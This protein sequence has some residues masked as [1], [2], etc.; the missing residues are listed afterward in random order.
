M[1]PAEIDNPQIIG[2]T[3]S[4]GSGCSYIAKN[5]LKKR[6]YEILSL[7][8]ILKEEF[9]TQKGKDAVKSPRRELQDFGDEIREEK[10]RDFL[11]SKVI[12]Q[13]DKSVAKNESKKWVVKSIRNPS[14]VLAFR[15]RS[16]NF[17]LFGVYADVE[18]RWNRVRGEYNN[19]KRQFDDDDRNDSGRN[20]PRHGQRVGDCFYEADVVIR[21]N[22]DFD[23]VGNA[24]FVRFEEQLEQYVQLT[25]EPLTRKKPIR[26]EEPLMAMAYALSQRSS[27][28]KRKVGAV[29]VDE[30]GNVVSS[31]YNEVPRHEQPCEQR[32][33][34]C[35]REWLYSELFKQLLGKF[36][37]L[38]GKEEELKKVFRGAFK[39]MDKCRALHAEDI[40]IV[41]LARSGTSVSLPSCVLYTTTYPCRQCASRISDAGIK[42]VIYLEPYP[43][44][45]AR[46]ILKGSGVND[47]FFE[48]VTFKAYFRLY[49]EEK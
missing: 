19:D 15:E 22:D 4:F 12:Q 18:V 32:Y 34:G 48:G 26:K 41:N 28:L 11:A 3:G 23:V 14:E 9:K 38:K 36:K 40:A 10:G 33:R 24:D 30:V 25:E 17:F 43:D 31:G 8:E 45:E 13:V 37:E 5:I 49:G 29:I 27:C 44:K 6:G 46:L 35:Y 39:M 21:N 20:N 7:A 47:Q 42:R 1:V 2:L 16:R